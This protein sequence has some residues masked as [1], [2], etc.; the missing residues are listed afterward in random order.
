[1]IED[2]FRNIGE[3]DFMEIVK[4]MEPEDFMNNLNMGVVITGRQ[5]DLMELK[6]LLYQ[7]AEAK[8]RLGFKVICV[9]ISNDRLALVR[10]DE[11]KDWKRT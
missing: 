5:L 8:A 1:M 6:Y 10:W 7:Y 3:L 11:W 4:S 9:N 2:K